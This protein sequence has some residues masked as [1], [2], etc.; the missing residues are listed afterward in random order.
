M[1]FNV[2]NIDNMQKDDLASVICIASSN[3]FVNVFNPKDNSNLI[4]LPDFGTLFLN[5]NP[6]AIRQEPIL[7][8][9]IR[10]LDTCFVS[11]SIARIEALAAV[12]GMFP[13]ANQARKNGFVGD[14]PGGFSQV[15]LRINKIRGVLTIFK[16]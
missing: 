14:I 8:S 4:K 11:N 7:G 16:M 6:D 10:D 1:N 15:I 2:V 3:K 5:T 9:L 12:V 13:S